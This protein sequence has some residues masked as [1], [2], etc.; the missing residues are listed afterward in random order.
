MIGNELEARGLQAPSNIT[1][2]DFKKIVLQKNI[3]ER[4][5]PLFEHA[6]RKQRF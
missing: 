2:T 6:E 3:K 1:F 4:Q 5:K